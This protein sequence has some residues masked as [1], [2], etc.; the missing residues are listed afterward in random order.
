MAKK[1]A[2]TQTKTEESMA[3]IPLDAPLEPGPAGELD[4]STPATLGAEEWA[5]LEKINTFLFY[6]PTQAN[7]ARANGYTEQEHELGKALWQKAAG[8][9]RPL[10]HWLAEQDQTAQPSSVSPSQARLLEE[11]DAFENVWLPRIKAM[12]ERAVPEENLEGFTSAF[13]KDLP[14][15]RQDLPTSTSLLLDRFEALESSGEP[16][17]R[18]LF[19]LGTERG[20]T[21]KKIE[22]I[23]ATIQATRVAHEGPAEAPKV[24]PEELGR[25]RA[26]QLAAFGKVRRWYNDW[27]T[28]F[29]SV[30]GPRI[31]GTLGLATP[32]RGRPPAEG[33]SS[34]GAGASSAD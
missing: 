31:Q 9:D 10:Y 2:G 17:A 16:G 26:E 30:F 5:V 14:R 8:R 7:A 22:Q 1:N 13:F 25:A 18:D 4:S 23:R 27:A 11:L 12:I 21:R 20:L 3:P 33:A 19:A 28:T 15:Q 34:N 24:S 32:K 29:R 6:I